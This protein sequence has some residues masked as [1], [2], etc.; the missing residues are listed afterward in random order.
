MPYVVA[1]GDERFELRE[2]AWT[3]KGPRSR[4]LATFVELAPGVI[5]QALARSRGA[6]TRAELVAAARRAG[7]SVPRPPADDAAVRLLAELEQGEELTP[8]IE[9]LLRD[10]LG[11][12]DAGEGSEATDS[13]RAAAAWLGR[14][15]AERG[16]AL[17]ELLSL[18]DRLPPSKRS[19]ELEFPPIK[20]TVDERA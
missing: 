18:T 13:E 20:T 17:R 6:T 10:R 5:E 9:R 15:L 16:Q 4:T 2:S 14:S 8:R 19:D 1:R 11:Q 3:S 12:G 7:A